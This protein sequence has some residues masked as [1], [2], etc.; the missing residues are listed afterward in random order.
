MSDLWQNWS[1]SVRCVPAQVVYPTS[2][3][4]IVQI[5]KDCRAK[6]R[7]LRVVGSGH[8]FTRLVETSGV[9]MSLDKYSGVEAFDRENLQATVRAG[10]KI[11]ALGDAL[12]NH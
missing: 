5:V 9:L 6:N 7:G 2:Q 8:S 3:E 4:E 12:F 10:T 1:G 11:K